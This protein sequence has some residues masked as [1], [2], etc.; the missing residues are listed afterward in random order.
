M[1]CPDCGALARVPGQAAHA[2]AAPRPAPASAAGA[3][4]AKDDWT[5]PAASATPAATVECPNCHRM[6][7]DGPMPCPGC[8]FDRKTG[9]GTAPAAKDGAAARDPG[10][11]PTSILPL[12]LGTILKPV[13]T[14]DLLLVHLSNGAL[15]AQALVFFAVALGVGT[16]GHRWILER[17]A[18]ARV[19]RFEREKQRL[20]EYADYAYERGKDFD[21]DAE[22]AAME[23][24][25]LKPAPSYGALLIG[26]T[27]ERQL[28]AVSTHA[29]AL[30]FG[31]NG[32]FLRV[33]V[34]L[35]FCAIGRGSRD[36]G[37]GTI[38]YLGAAASSA[39]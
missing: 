23:N 20:E 1:Y 25:V 18:E 24:R 30:L 15:L 8:G 22:N 7:P 31:G 39:C 14:M 32:N 26:V 35:A 11:A 37:F 2:P 10:A 28:I 29:V 13:S 36:R 4:P 27:L 16:W 38:L 17:E 21:L 6:T 12:I 3:T 34:T 19:A 9:K 5:K 33:L